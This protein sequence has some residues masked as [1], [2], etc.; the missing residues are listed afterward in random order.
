MRKRLLDQ[1]RE[2]RG[3]VIPLAPGWRGTQGGRCRVDLGGGKHK[4][5]RLLLASGC[6]GTQER[7]MPAG[8]R[9]GRGT[10]ERPAAAQK[11]GARDVL[12]EYERRGCPAEHA[13]IGLPGKVASYEPRGSPFRT[14]WQAKHGY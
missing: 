14:R 11:V 2:R 7:P 9:V 3:R 1:A 4:S 13:A 8:A 10:Q 5:G 6:S 12:P